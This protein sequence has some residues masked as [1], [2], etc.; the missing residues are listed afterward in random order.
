MILKNKCSAT[1]EA[2]ITINL[3]CCQ[4]NQYMSTIIRPLNLFYS[5]K[6]AKHKEKK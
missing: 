5:P 6:L 1:F 4:A 3:P 2:L